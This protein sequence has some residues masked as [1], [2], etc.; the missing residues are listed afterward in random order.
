MPAMR[1]GVL[2]FALI[3]MLND[4]GGQRQPARSATL[5]TEDSPLTT[6]HSSLSFAGA[7]TNV[8]S[9]NSTS[10]I[11]KAG[12]PD[13]QPGWRASASSNSRVDFDTQIKPI[14][15]SRC[16]PC[17]FSG[18]AQY[19]KLPFD[20]P[21]TIKKLGTKTLHSHPGRKSPPSHPR[22]P[23]AIAAALRIPFHFEG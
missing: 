11:R 13:G 22:L 15:Q 2:V 21:E 5:W 18:G 23:G 14:L 6:P 1:T 8:A 16:M 10:E 12:S 17:H 7:S 3:F 9:S 20:R 4:W 19:E